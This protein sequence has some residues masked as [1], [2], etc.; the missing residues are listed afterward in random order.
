V[1]SILAENPPLKRTTRRYPSYAEIEDPAERR[2][3][4]IRLHAE[5]L[6][7]TSI[8]K[9][10]E[11]SRQTVYTVLKRWIDEGVR[12]LDD[13]SHAPKHAIRGK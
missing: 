5:G 6:R 8:A 3:A 13:K 10:L 4:V 12:G 9:S 7:V 11:T 1:Q 2:L